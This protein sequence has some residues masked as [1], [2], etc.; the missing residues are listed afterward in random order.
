MKLLFTILITLIVNVLYS[1]NDININDDKASLSFYE[2]LEES[3]LEYS[4]DNIENSNG[5][6]VRIWKG[7]EVMTFGDSSSY[8]KRFSNLKT[9]MVYLYKQ[10]LNLRLDTISISSLKSSEIKFYIDCF[11]A[12]VEISENNKYFLKVVQC[13]E[14]IRAVINEIYN[15]EIQ[16]NIENYIKT[17]PSGEYPNNMTTFSIN[18]PISDESKKSDF[19]KKLEVDLSK[20]EINIDNSTKQ[21]LI[22][23]NSRKVY[24]EDVNKLNESKIKSIEILNHEQGIIYG[25]SGENGV[26]L[27]KTNE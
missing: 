7:Q 25:T 3:L 6:I 14:N 16:L 24:F 13:N 20:K 22:L 15:K 27:I 17:L 2:N 10:Q 8:V 4:I 21:P 18:Q 26:V 11:P 23:V 12:A 1:Q 5:R 19:Y 9:G